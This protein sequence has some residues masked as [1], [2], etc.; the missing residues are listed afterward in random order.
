MPRYV[1]N[2]IVVGGLTLSG[3]AH[4]ASPSGD[5]AAGANVAKA[6]CAACHDISNAAPRRQQ[7]RMPAV[8]P[9]FFDVAQDATHTTEWFRRFLRLP[10]GQMDNVTLTRADIDNVSAYI[11]GM[12][13]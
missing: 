3:L 13:K 8:P 12:R 1:F 10:H 5:A 11:Q 7:P 9:A 4:A 6:I 2:A